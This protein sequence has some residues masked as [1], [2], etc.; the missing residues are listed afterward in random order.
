MMTAAAALI[1][2]TY[3]ETAHQRG[4]RYLKFRRRDSHDLSRDAV[5]WED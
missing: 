2:L 5:V 4:N 3:R 1:L